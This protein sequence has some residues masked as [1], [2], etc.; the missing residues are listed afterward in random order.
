MIFF[1]TDKEEQINQPEAVRDKML[2]TERSAEFDPETKARRA[3]TCQSRPP[4]RFTKHT[5]THTHKVKTIS[6]QAA[7][8]G[9]NQNNR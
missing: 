4:N 6:R 7:T 2:A 8:A 1:K 3:D 5:D 9:N